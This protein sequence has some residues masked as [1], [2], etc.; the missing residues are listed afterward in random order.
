MKMFSWELW[1]FCFDELRQFT[2]FGSGALA[3][4]LRAL[5]QALPR[6]IVI[7]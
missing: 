3:D 2:D 1:L 6:R 7:R 4:A 5:P